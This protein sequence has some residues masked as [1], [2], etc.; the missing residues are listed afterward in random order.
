M[1]VD[2][3]STITVTIDQATD[4]LVFNTGMDL[5]KLGNLGIGFI[6]GIAAYEAQGCDLTVTCNANAAVRKVAPAVVNA[7]SVWLEVPVNQ[8]DLV[9]GDNNAGVQDISW[10]TNAAAKTDMSAQHQ[11]LICLLEQHKADIEVAT[12]HLESLR[13]Q[14]SLAQ[15]RLVSLFQPI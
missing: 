10:L 15:D 14:E 4:R 1:K 6:D 2:S 11:L 7:L 13:E 12:S 3:K 9:A 5:S 8:L